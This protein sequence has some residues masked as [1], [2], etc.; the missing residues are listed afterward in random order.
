MYT[1]RGGRGK[2]CSPPGVVEKRVEELSKSQG[3]AFLTVYF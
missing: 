2:D 3:R 1:I